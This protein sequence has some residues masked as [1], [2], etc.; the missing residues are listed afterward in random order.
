MDG[1]YPSKRGTIAA[2]SGSTGDH[3]T[4]EDDQQNE[5]N[6]CPKIKR[7]IGVFSQG[8]RRILHHFGA[9]CLLMKRAFQKPGRSR[10]Y[11]KALAREIDYLG[12]DSV[13]IVGII[14]LFVGAV[15]T[16]Q[17][18]L[19]LDDP[20]IPDYY[21]AIA[22]RESIILEFSPTMVSLIL[23]GKVGSNI[24]STLGTMRVSEQI[25]AL[26]VMG[27]NSASYLVMPKV[28]ASMLF[29]PILI[30]LSMGLGLLGGYIAGN[31]TGVISTPDYLLGI[32]LGFKPFYITYAMTKTVVFAFLITS[33]S[34]YYG[35]TVKGGAVEVGTSS[36]RAVVSSSVAVIVANYFLT[37]I[38]LGT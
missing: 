4:Q 28:L 30:M 8:M 10:E 26:E 17:T 15:V 6:H 16:I 1:P 12:L 27:V 7:Q 19:N 21:I 34:A 14:S 18:A 37:Q 38:L 35:Y 2:V 5:S 25:D 23:A 20:F 36:T 9:Y 11:G 24:A 3:E 13:A 22:T 33:I 29:N 31:L 32:Q